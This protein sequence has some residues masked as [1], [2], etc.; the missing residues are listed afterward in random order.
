MA[1]CQRLPALGGSRCDGAGVEAKTSWLPYASICATISGAM[2]I[3]AHK[4]PGDLL[5]APP[6]R[7]QKRRRGGAHPGE[8]GT[9]P[10]SASSPLKKGGWIG[11]RRE[12]GGWSKTDVACS[13]ASRLQRVARRATEGDQRHVF[14]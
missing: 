7:C 9:R 6:D 11:G 14:P 12:A 8:L 4:G 13:Y 2:S 3:C 5:A 1:A 10:Q